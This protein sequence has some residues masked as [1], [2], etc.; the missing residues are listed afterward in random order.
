MWLVSTIESLTNFPCQMK[1]ECIFFKFHTFCGIL[2]FLF[3]LAKSKTLSSYLVIYKW[4]FLR[5]L[6]R[7]YIDRWV[8]VSLKFKKNR[9][10]CYFL[11]H[12]HFII[13][14]S[15]NKLNNSV[16]SFLQEDSKIIVLQFEIR[17]NMYTSLIFFIE[18]SFKEKVTCFTEQRIWCE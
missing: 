12:V 11:K 8:E 15:I 7:Y 10:H 6:T 9:L 4:Q 5:I 16:L 13:T 1:L 17:L 18:N 2:I 3:A 14:F